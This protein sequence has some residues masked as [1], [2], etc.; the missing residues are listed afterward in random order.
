[1][2]TELSKTEADYLLSTLNHKAFL[3][4]YFPKKLDDFKQIT[5]EILQ[6]IDSTMDKRVQFSQAEMQDFEI[7]L[8]ALVKSLSNQIH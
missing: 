8:S 4:P 6:M 7:Y 3:I 1:M 5:Q 2:K